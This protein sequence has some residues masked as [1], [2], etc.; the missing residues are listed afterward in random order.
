MFL[1]VLDDRHLLQI[2]KKLG[3][4]WEPL[5]KGLSV[6][7]GE[8]AEIIESE[9]KTYQGC[10]KML[11]NWRESKTDLSEGL[12]TLTQQLK[13]INRMDAVLLLQ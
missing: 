2:A 5:A 7:S 1:E 3:G 12:G 13:A 8:I 6:S 9:G 4:D 11:W 10:F